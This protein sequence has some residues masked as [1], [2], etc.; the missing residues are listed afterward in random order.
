MSR[1]AAILLRRQ[2]AI[3]AEREAT[4]AAVLV[5]VLHNER[6]CAARLHPEAEAGTFRFLRHVSTPLSAMIRPG[7]RN[8]AMH[9]AMLVQ[10]PDRRTPSDFHVSKLELSEK[11]QLPFREWELR[12]THRCFCFAR[13]IS[14]I[15]FLAIA[16]VLEYQKWLGQ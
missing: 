15:Q 2:N 16:S 8:G 11:Q 4:A 7:S 1:E 10:A 14:I 6:F 5:A 13:A 9:L 12:M 3:A